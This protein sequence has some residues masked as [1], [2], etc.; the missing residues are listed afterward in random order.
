MNKL[1]IGV[2]CLLIFGAYGITA[3]IAGQNKTDEMCIPM[4]PILLEPPESVKQKRSLVDFPHPRH[5]GYS[6]QACHHTWT[7]KVK[8]LD[9]TTSNCHDLKQAPKK[10]AG[11]DLAIRYYKK[12]FH[13]Q[14]QGCHKELKK[15][16]KRME[17]LQN[18]A[19][20]KLMKTG[21]TG[22]VECHPK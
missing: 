18:L 14:C 1:R 8:I 20:S 4:G 10:A 5:F 21:P 12:A 16:N 2:V 13:K 6:C 11:K 17:K 3:G 7:G 22:C 15:K 9:C 19:E